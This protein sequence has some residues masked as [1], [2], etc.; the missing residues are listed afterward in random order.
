MY[1]IRYSRCR[2]SR[3]ILPRVRHGCF[4]DVTMVLDDYPV[5]TCRCQLQEWRLAAMSVYLDPPVRLVVHAVA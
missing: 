2:I 3:H 4:F 5:V 1:V